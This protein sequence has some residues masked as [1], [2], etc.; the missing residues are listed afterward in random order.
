MAVFWG[1]YL[2]A[3]ANAA[4]SS[5]SQASKKPPNVFSKAVEYEV[6]SLCTGYQIV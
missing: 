6:G 3:Y 4:W 2:E 5:N 1:V